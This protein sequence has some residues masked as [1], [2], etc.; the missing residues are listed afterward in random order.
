MI[1]L[2]LATVMCGG[3]FA[4]VAP[5][6]KLKV[7]ATAMGGTGVSLVGVG[8]HTFVARS[9][10]F[11]I[12]EVGIAHPD[13]DWLEL[14][15]SVMLE[16]EG[17]VGF[18]LLPKIRA[19]LP[20]KRVRFWGS[21]ALPIFVVPYSLLGVQVGAGVSVALHPRIALVAEFTATAYVW[22]SDLIK[23]TA[24]G[25]LDESFGLKVSF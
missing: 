7:S 17:R 3:L 12:G 6:E 11:I 24:L 10:T 5:A 19:R 2:F 22:G 14:A 16:L 15:P 13:L 20:G 23:K 9:P 4:G 21:A 8:K 18:A 1:P 25:K